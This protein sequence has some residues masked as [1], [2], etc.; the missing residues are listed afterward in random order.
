MAHRSKV[1][2]V[3]EAVL[4]RGQVGCGE[5]SASCPVSRITAAAQLEHSAVEWPEWQPRDAG[6][7]HGQRRAED[8]HSIV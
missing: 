6:S 2:K 4:Q 3:Q 7:L 5:H 8:G 1:Q